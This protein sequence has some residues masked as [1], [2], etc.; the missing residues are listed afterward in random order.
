MRL[1]MRKLPFLFIMCAVLMTS[2]SKRDDNGL[3]GGNWRTD[4]NV[5]LAIYTDLAQWKK[6]RTND[7]YLGCFRHTDDSLIFTLKDG[8][9]RGLYHNKWSADVKDTLVTNADSVPAEFQMPLNFGFR[10]QK[11]TTDSLVLQADGKTMR[12]RRY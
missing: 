4:S 6:G 9:R 1:K 5:F 3:L 10:I 12:F 8:K 11:L 2:C 7:Y